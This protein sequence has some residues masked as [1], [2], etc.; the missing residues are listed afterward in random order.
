MRM[1]FALVVVVLFAGCPKQEATPTGAPP[2]TQGKPATDRGP[3]KTPST[4]KIDISDKLPKTIPVRDWT[5]GKE[6][7]PLEGHPAKED[8]RVAFLTDGK[9]LLC[10]DRFTVRAWDIDQRKAVKER[11]VAKQNLGQDLATLA[12]SPD[13]KFAAVGGYKILALL[14]AD[15]LAVKES[16]EFGKGIQWLEV[17]SLSFAPNGK[18]LLVGGMIDLRTNVDDIVNVVLV[19]DVASWN[20][21]DYFKTGSDKHKCS[22]LA[23]LPDGQ[24]AFVDLTDAD[25]F[26]V[27]VNNIHMH[28]APVVGKCPGI[29]VE[30]RGGFAVSP[31]G[32]TCLLATRHVDPKVANGVLLCDVG[33][34]AELQ[35]FELPPHGEDNVNFIDAVAYSPDGKHAAFVGRHRGDPD[36]P[37]QDAVVIVFDVKDWKEVTRFAVKTPGFGSVAFSPDGQFL[38]VGTRSGFIA[39][40]QAP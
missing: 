8:L 38:A 28:G 9:H 10:A 5:K 12:V 4:Q 32:K 30:S 39:V 16:L 36:R 14:D 25:M 2:T 21:E 23:Y 17:A 26:Q 1:L 15:T 27:D 24:Y 3:K 37:D 34:N 22:R 29:R 40:Y 7:G 35:K 31:D 33:N 13:G 20:D 18:R 6:L 19:R 11:T